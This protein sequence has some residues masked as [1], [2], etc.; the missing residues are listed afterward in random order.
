M[1]R[2]LNHQ[3]NIFSKNHEA[4]LRGMESLGRSFALNKSFAEAIKVWEERVS[5]SKTPMEKAYLFHE[6]GRC[7]LELGQFEISIHY[8][9]IAFEEAKLANDGNW[10][11][12]SLILLGQSYC[13]F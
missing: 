12:N 11:T 2:L 6:I 5:L 3:C 1:C 10:K 8:A 13:K 4:K 7:Y 9:S